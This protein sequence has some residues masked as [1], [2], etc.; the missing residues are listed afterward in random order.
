LSIDP[1][2]NEG[3]AERYDTVLYAARP[4]AQTHPVHLATIASLFGLAPPDPATC[5]VLEVGCND[6]ANLIPMAVSLPRARFVGCDLSPRAL[7]A[8]RAVIDAIGLSN[9]ELVQRDI[10]ALDPSFGEF[11]YI[12]ARGFYS[13]VPAPVREALL[14]LAATRLS[15]Q[16]VMFLSYN[17]FPG[18]YIR[19]AAWDVIHRHVDRIENVRE[20]L[21]TARAFARVLASAGP[22]Q[23]PSDEALRG[24]F[25]RVAELDDSALFHDDLAIPNDPMWFRDVVEACARHNLEFVAETDMQT[26]SAWQLPAEARQLLA[27]LDRL[28]REQYLDFMSV[29]RYRQ[30][31][32]TRGASAS[33]FRLAPQSVASMVVGASPTLRRARAQNSVASLAELLDPGRGP[34]GPIRTML[35]LLV[36]RYPDSLTQGTLHAVMAAQGARLSRPLEAI[37]AQA[38]VS[39]IVQLRVMASPAGMTPGARP[40]ASPLARHQARESLDVTNLM[41]ESVRLPDDRSRRLL[42]LLD[43]NRDEAA[44]CAALDAPLDAAAKLRYVRES[45]A[46]FARRALLFSDQRSEP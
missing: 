14:A 13:W 39:D 26:M 41:Q 25:K 18:G 7:A 3:L 35:D 1:A 11:D 20:R 15:P 30:S 45:L 37:L 23:M 24:E 22:L 36:Q 10:A 17:T 19:K 44:I 42:Q 43:G 38:F 2:S 6:G 32:F 12:I 28:G 9:I 40:R 16:G 27:S 4:A 31:L 46:D 29:R 8:G 34:A 33:G 5:R 21:D